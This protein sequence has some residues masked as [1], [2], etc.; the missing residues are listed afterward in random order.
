MMKTIGILGLQG[1]YFEHERVLKNLGLTSIIVK[2]GKA[3]DDLDGLIIP[4]GESSVMSKLIREQNL[5]A[6]LTNLISV[7]KKP[8]LATCAGLILLSK[9]LL[10]DD[11]LVP[12]LIP[13]LD[14]VVQRNAYGGQTHSFMERLRL[15]G[16]GDYNCLFIR[17]PK[18]VEVKQGQVL[19][20][21]REDPVM[22]RHNNILVC[23][24][25]PELQDTLVHNFFFNQG[26]H[27]N[28]TSPKG[29]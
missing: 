25:H 19:A 10:S 1:N 11:Q 26:S 14:I 16:I 29:S 23:S 5:L 24:F 20:K 2:T 27:N 22:V 7:Q 13:V 15:E 28:N 12:G 9:Y 6:P 3:L 4:G 21:Y 17:A 18:I 8:V